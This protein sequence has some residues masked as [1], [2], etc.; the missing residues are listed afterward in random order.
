MIDLR[1]RRRLLSRAIPFIQPIIDSM[2]PM[3]RE[4]RTQATVLDQ[5]FAVLLALLETVPTFIGGNELATVLRTAITHRLKAERASSAVI[6]KA[7]KNIPTKT[8]FPVV[9]ELWKSLQNEDE[10]V[11]RLY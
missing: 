6:S 4:P 3:I 8:M 10:T 9:V 11:S 5:A 1:H 7:A 2:L